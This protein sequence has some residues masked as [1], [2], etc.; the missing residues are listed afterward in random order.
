MD[1]IEA[2]FSQIL[3]ALNTELSAATP[4]AQSAHF[5]RFTA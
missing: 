5:S 3:G 1:Q 2:T 4:M